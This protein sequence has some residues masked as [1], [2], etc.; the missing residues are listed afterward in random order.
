MKHAK[1]RLT[2]TYLYADK[3]AVQIWEKQDPDA[4]TI[5][6]V[7]VIERYTEAYCTFTGRLIFGRWHEAV[8]NLC[9]RA[10]GIRAEAPEVGRGS[11]ATRKH[12]LAVGTLELHIKEG[13]I[14]WHDMPS[15]ISSCYTYQPDQCE[16]FNPD[17]ASWSDRRVARIHRAKAVAS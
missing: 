7:E 6:Y 10:S 9:R 14:H 8:A 4:G 15:L 12:G 17:L 1:P 3:H 13:Q 16:T 11:D 2:V 5:E